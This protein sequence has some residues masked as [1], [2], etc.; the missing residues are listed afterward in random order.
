MAESDGSSKYEIGDLVEMLVSGRLALI[1][2]VSCHPSGVKGEWVSQYAIMEYEGCRSEFEDKAWFYD[3]DIRRLVEPSASRKHLEYKRG[4][5]KNDSTE[6]RCL[7][8]GSL[9]HEMVP[10]Q[11]EGYQ[12]YHNRCICC[13]LSYPDSYPPNLKRHAKRGEVLA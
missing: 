9:V 13:G 7:C 3:C 5:Q 8:G 1:R 10:G 6:W 2:N 12:M 4:L 11:W